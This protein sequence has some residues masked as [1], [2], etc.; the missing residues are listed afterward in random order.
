MRDLYRP[1]SLYGPGP[2]PRKLGKTVFL[3]LLLVLAAGAA[4]SYFHPEDLDKVLALVR[5]TRP[6]V[7]SLAVR[8]NGVEKNLRPGQFLTLHPQDRLV[9]EGF[10]SNRIGNYNLALFSPDLDMAALQAPVRLLDLLGEDAFASPKQVVIQVREDQTPVASFYLLASM[11]AID[12]KDRAERA[13]D[14]EK[15]THYLRLALALD[16]KNETIVQDLAD[17]LDQKG[18]APSALSLREKIPLTENDT[19]FLKKLLDGYRA[20]GDRNKLV[21]TYHRLIMA[22]P[23]DEAETYLNELAEL[24]RSNQ[25]FEDAVRTYE[26]LLGRLP[27]DRGPE[28]LDK[29]LAIYQETGDYSKSADV[30]ERLIMASPESTSLGYVEKLAS[31]RQEHGQ[32]REAVQTY[33]DYIAGIPPAQAFDP[34]HKLLDLHRRQGDAAGVEKTCLRLLPLAP[35]GEKAALVGELVQS[36]REQ[37]RLQEAADALE[38]HLAT[39]PGSASPPLLREALAIYRA[40]D[41]YPSILAAYRRLLEVASPEEKTGLVREL[42]EL[43]Q[44][45]GEL[46]EAARTYEDFLAGNDRGQADILKSLLEIHRAAN[47]SKKVEETYRRL[48]AVV[49]THLA[50]PLV[51]ELAGL[52]DGQ[53]RSD[54]AARAYRDFIDGL[55]REQRAGPFKELGF[56]LAK[57]DKIPEAIAAYSAAAELDQNDPNLYLNL[58]RLYQ[59]AGDAGKA[60]AALEADA[61]KDK[62]DAALLLELAGLHHSRGDAE[63]YRAYL[64]QALETEPGNLESR[65]KLA[66]ALSDAGQ[67]AQAEKELVLALEKHPDS[68]E[69]RLALVGIMEKK[70]D[71]GPLIGHYEYL[72][73]QKPEDKVLK[74]NLGVLYFQARAFDKAEKVM[75]ALADHDPDDF[76]AREYLFEIH[77]A[78]KQG[79]KAY[80]T[81][82]E[83]IRLRPDQDGPY[84]YIFNYLD[85]ARNYRQLLLEAQNWC[86]KRP[87]SIRFREILALAQI[88]L[89]RLSD[90]SKTYE[91]IS[92]L[93]P[94]DLEILFNLGSIYEAQGRFNDAMS[95]Y[96]RIRKVD[97]DNARAAEAHLRVSLKKLESKVGK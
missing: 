72:L 52:L 55:P 83:L 15:K 81:A 10:D 87:E 27:V 17:L 92:R 24:H 60:I 59:A 2:P 79:K 49:P 94:T 1:S 63:K 34:L 71:K 74:Y 64:A 16:P 28:A 61:L 20:V 88:K 89:G 85:Q 80:Q 5:P 11:R 32:P 7:K 9:V 75:Q 13:V 23:R 36:L 68:L 44:A 86:G 69:A 30:L 93:Q 54:D 77:L 6:E 76:D 53:G 26:F 21:H 51:Q 33:E 65:L 95:A 50:W 56:I 38:N 78:K 35:P 84:E 70:P 39:V 19:A 37:G 14:L 48:I 57:G 90:A 8:V 12:W 4:W 41:N 25:E 66:E 29:I 42:A 3:I 45:R 91:E 82:Q 31:L 46:G 96:G 97:P 43:Q 22:A 58:A 18:D 40:M 62:R 47:D 67:E 73:A